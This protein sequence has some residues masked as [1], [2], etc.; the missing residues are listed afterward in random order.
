MTQQQQ[1]QGAKLQ[2]GVTSRPA[3]CFSEQ[4]K[5]Q[6]SRQEKGKDSSTPKG[7]EAVTMCDAALPVML[8]MDCQERRQAAR[9]QKLRAGRSCPGRKQWQAVLVVSLLQTKSWG[10]Q[11]WLRLA[12]GSID[13][14]PPAGARGAGATSK[15]GAVT[16]ST[17]DDPT[18]LLWD[19]KAST[20][21][22][23]TAAGCTC[24]HLPAAVPPSH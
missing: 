24:G 4:M 6:S 9:C 3:Q 10:Y 11:H 5:G 15:Q 17:R 18:A 19:A 23:A 16:G 8:A 1:A 2:A 22:Q 7:P 21:R 12:A 20:I 14:E 13:T